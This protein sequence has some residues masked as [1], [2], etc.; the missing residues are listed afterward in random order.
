MKILSKNTKLKKGEGAN[1]L[2]YGVQLAAHKMSGYNVCPAA[3]KGC[4]AACL[5]GSGFARI[6][7]HVNAGR[8]AKTRR[9]FEDREGFMSDLRADIR[10][11][12]RQAQ[13]KGLKLAIR[14]NTLSDIPWENTGIFAEFPDIQFYDYGKTL[15]RFAPDSLARSF[16]NYHLTFSRSESNEKHVRQVIEWGVNVA[17]VFRGALPATYMGRPVIDGDVNDLRFLDPQGVIVGLVEKKTAHSDT[18][19]FVVEP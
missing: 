5:V 13:K 11:A 4:A 7:K 16:P 12:I 2:T 9:Y 19:G 14:L 18:S 1:W 17:V 15:K 6:Y 3:S 8:I 10:L